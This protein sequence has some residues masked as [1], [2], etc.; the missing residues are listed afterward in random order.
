MST[1]LPL[2]CDANLPRAIHSM[3]G[4][5][6]R[7]PLWISHAVVYIASHAPSLRHSQHSSV[8]HPQCEAVRR[9]CKT[10]NHT[11]NM[12]PSIS[13]RILKILN[14]TANL[15]RDKL[16]EHVGTRSYLALLKVNLERQFE[17]PHLKSNQIYHQLVKVW[18]I[19]ST[20]KCNGTGQSL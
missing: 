15:R 7:C 20:I 18:G 10:C 2:Q 5:A 1:I 3:L 9:F 6:I 12:F 19:T 14:A 13:C 17:I 11:E 4:N 8:Y 16:R